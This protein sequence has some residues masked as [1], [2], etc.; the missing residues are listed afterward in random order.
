[1]NA[2]LSRADLL[3]RRSIALSGVPEHDEVAVGLDLSLTSTGWAAIRRGRM[4]GFAVS[5]P[6]GI[7]GAERLYFFE[8]ELVGLLARYEP[9]MVAVEGYSFGSRNGREQAGEL[10]GIARLV[11]HKAKVPWFTVPPQ[12][13]KAFA[14]GKG[15]AEKSA[16]GKELFKR[17][18]VDLPGNDATDAGGLALIAFSRLHSGLTLTQAQKDTLQKI[19][20]PGAKSVD[21]KSGS[22]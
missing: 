10:G 18:G 21:K 5:P 15:T 7:V 8:K 11:L 9:H 1:M 4:I 13:L 17:W 14:T 2:P 12:S 16:V 22:R 6:A 20:Q 3:W 19:L